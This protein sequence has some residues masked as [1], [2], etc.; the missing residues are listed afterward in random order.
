M[1]IIK[2][3]IILMIFPS[4]VFA[5]SL[6]ND[7]NERT[8][9]I[10]P[11]GG[12][13][14][15]ITIYNDSSKQDNILV[16]LLDGATTKSGV[17]ALIDYKDNQ[18]L[19]G[20]W[21]KLE[22]ETLSMEPKEKK[23]ISYQI[24]TPSNITPGVYSGGI[25]LYKVDNNNIGKQNNKAK[26]VSFQSRKV[27]QIVVNIAG[28][29]YNKLEITDVKPK[30]N[31]N[32][33][34]Y[35]LK[36][37][38]EN[39]GTTVN[40]IK[41]NINITSIITGKQVMDKENNMILFAGDSGMSSFLWEQL[42]LLD[43]VKIKKNIQFYEKDIS[44]NKIKLIGNKTYTTYI[45]VYNILVATIVILLLLLLIVIYSIKKYLLHNL[46]Q[47][48]NEYIIKEGDTLLKL[49]E[50][51]KMKWK[52]L[53]KLNKIKAPYTLNKNQK[54]FIPKIKK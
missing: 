18:K 20:K 40:K 54:I 53:A 21:G 12:V 27:Y 10:K 11:G 44:Q 13:K 24:Q 9:N 39:K 7:L 3:L 8:F 16:K 23:T 26:G 5:S 22:I 6:T 52:I 14:S 37:Q 45:F 36:T 4:V 1:K 49:A 32:K 2:S 48:S 46:R 34:N 47:N 41:E 50:K 51:N 30:Y 33:K 17:F 35:I 28:E 19:I 15:S 29:K 38:F 42:P 31:F 43:I 25:A